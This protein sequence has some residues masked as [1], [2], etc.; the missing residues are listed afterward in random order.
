MR[1]VV[2]YIEMLIMRLSDNTNTSTSHTF[3]SCMA[4]SRSCWCHPHLCLPSTK[5][6]TSSWGWRVCRLQGDQGTR[7]HHGDWQLGHHQLVGV[8]AAIT[9]SISAI[10]AAANQLKFHGCS[11]RLNR[12]R[13]SKLLSAVHLCFEV[14]KGKV[15][16]CWTS[17]YFFWIPTLVLIDARFLLGDSLPATTGLIL[18]R[19]WLGGAFRPAPA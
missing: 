2:K 7:H 13:R 5:C 10:R 11:G 3:R 16:N 18:F 8:L 1:I 19:L 15:L 12:F 9:C 17:H 14:Q 6:R 4:S